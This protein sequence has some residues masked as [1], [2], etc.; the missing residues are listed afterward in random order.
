MYGVEASFPLSELKN[1]EIENGAI[2]Y[3]AIIDYDNATYSEYTLIKSKATFIF[4]DLLMIPCIAAILIY[5][6]IGLQKNGKK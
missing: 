1:L 2:E 5:Y 3:K 4:T 6:S